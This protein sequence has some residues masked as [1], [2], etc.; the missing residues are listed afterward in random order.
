MPTSSLSAVFVFSF[1]VGFGAV[2]SPGPVAT[3]IVSQSPRHGWITG[4][5]VVT[6]HSFLELVIV[7]LIALGLSAGM[8]QPSIQ[9]VIAL[10]GG[11]LLMWMGGSMLWG[12]LRGKVHLP[13][14]G[15]E[16]ES[17]TRWQ[18]VRL[19]MVATVLNPF[20]YAW[21]MTVAA[22]YLAEARSEITAEGVPTT[23]PV[24]ADRS[25]RPSRGRTSV[26]ATPATRRSPTKPR[27]R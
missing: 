21:W 6:G 26:P 3:A 19:G 10:L 5:L 23:N 9:V 15:A 20:W 14:S 1:V 24:P 27:P 11:L 7:V 12:I 25:P 4:P 2:V 22:G 17:M 8:A 18:L 16:T 13:G